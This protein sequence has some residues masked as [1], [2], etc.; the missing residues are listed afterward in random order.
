[1]KKVTLTL[2]LILGA[3]TFAL[4]LRSQQAAATAVHRSVSHYDE[5]KLSQPRYEV[6]T[7]ANVRVPMR[8]GVTLS[9]DIFHPDAPGKFPAI[10][11]RNPYG[12]ATNVSVPQARCFAAGCARALGFGW[13]LLRIQKRSRR[14]V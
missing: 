11:I 2:A 6:L 12:K 1:M 13:P 3:A 4:T 9:T 7:E 5:T 8:D 14:R 10:L